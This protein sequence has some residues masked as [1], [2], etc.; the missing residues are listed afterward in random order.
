MLVHKQLEIYSIFLKRLPDGQLWPIRSY[1]Y[2]SFHKN[3]IDFTQDY[4]LEC[5]IY[6]YCQ[7]FQWAIVKS[8]YSEQGKSESTKNKDKDHESRKQDKT[9]RTIADDMTSSKLKKMPG[10][11]WW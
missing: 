7:L 11:W 2:K 8:P 9:E 10:W 3:A 1:I 4:W 5:V 6:L